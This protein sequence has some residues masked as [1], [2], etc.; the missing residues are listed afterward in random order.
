[1]KSRNEPCI[2]PNPSEA[3]SIQ[4]QVIVH[5]QLLYQLVLFKT[6]YNSVNFHDFIMTSQYEHF[7]KFGVNHKLRLVARFELN[8]IMKKG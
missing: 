3:L 5:H 6:I 1:M 4:G 7:Y 8:I 2:L